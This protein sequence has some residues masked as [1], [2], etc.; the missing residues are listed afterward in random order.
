MSNDHILCNLNT[1]IPNF[2]IPAMSYGTLS[3]TLFSLA[4]P[5]SFVL[6]SADTHDSEQGL[7][8]MGFCLA[9]LAG[10][11]QRNLYSRM[12]RSPAASSDSA[13]RLHSWPKTLALSSPYLCWEADSGFDPFVK[14]SQE[15]MVSNLLFPRVLLWVLALRWGSAFPG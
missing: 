7:L 13:A 2:F 10:Q 3:P 12:Q 1:P 15:G 5:P 9:T 11:R 6:T 14:I 4:A 8:R